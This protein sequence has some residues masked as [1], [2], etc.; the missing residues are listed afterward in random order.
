MNLV[1]KKAVTKQW[2]VKDLFEA[3]ESFNKEIRKKET[4]NVSLFEYII[5]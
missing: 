1:V 4:R 2:K 3:M 5:K